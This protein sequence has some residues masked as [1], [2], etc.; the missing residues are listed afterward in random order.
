MITRKGRARFR[1][2]CRGVPGARGKYT[3]HGLHCGERVGLGRDG[4][5]T[6]RKSNKVTAYAGS[7]PHRYVRSLV[8][9]CAS[10]ARRAPTKRVGGLSLGTAED[11]GVSPG[12]LRWR[13]QGRT[14]QSHMCTA[15][16]YTARATEVHV[17]LWKRFKQV[18]RR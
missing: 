1:V 2:H 14:A 10:R 11:G 12:L 3:L 13:D 5:A 6:M 8:E 15:S 17:I 16:A 4:R 9:R 7:R 18:S